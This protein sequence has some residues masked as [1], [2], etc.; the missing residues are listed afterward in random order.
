MDH[1]KILLLHKGYSSFVKADEELLK[2]H[3]HV[4]TYY[5]NPSKKLLKFFYYHVRFF[6]FMLFHLRKYN[7]IYTWFGDYHAYHAGAL[8]NLFNIKNIIV[9]GGNDAVSIPTIQYGVFYKKNLRSKLIIK[10]YKNADAILCVD[11]SLIRGDNNYIDGDNQVGLESFIPGISKKCYVVPTGYNADYWNCDR[12]K[13]TNQVLTVG[14]VD[15]ENRAILKGLD[16]IA[17]LAY[18]LPGIH[19]IFIGVVNDSILLNTKRKNLTIIDKVDQKT[20]KQYYCQSKV[21]VQFSVTEG[22][23][24]TL[25]E[26]MLC[27]C[28]AAGSNVNGIPNVIRNKEFILEKR[29]ADKAEKIIL[30]ALDTYQKIGEENRE[31][32]KEFYSEEI[33]EKELVRIIKDIVK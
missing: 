21:Y 23:P 19:F 25:C 30:K 8:S 32:I 7:L 18:R 3:F 33:R 28:I 1:I 27:K 16:L 22:L 12:E 24:N 29:D 13:K 2:K 26:A 6:I 31:F 9:V 17:Q 15:S 10:A 11:K 20:L 5:L 14:I 4:T